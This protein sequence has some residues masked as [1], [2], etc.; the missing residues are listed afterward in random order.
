MKYNDIIDNNIKKKHT[1]TIDPIIDINNNSISKID[2]NVF[3]T[4]TNNN[5]NI[6]NRKGGKFEID[7]VNIIDIAQFTNI[8]I[9]DVTYIPS[10]DNNDSLSHEFQYNSNISSLPTNLTP[11]IIIR[12]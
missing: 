11:N 5:N 2:N 9:Q 1:N 6:N 10:Q 3:D 12:I 7:V 8:K 4:S